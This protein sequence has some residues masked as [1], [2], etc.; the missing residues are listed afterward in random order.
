MGLQFRYNISRG[1]TTYA[2]MPQAL[3]EEKT[4]DDAKMSLRAAEF[5]A[6]AGGNYELLPKGN[7]QM[8]WECGVDLAPPATI[9]PRKPKMWSVKKLTMERSKA[10]KVM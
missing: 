2:F 10:Y 1:P 8:L 5:G 4:T 3:S 6:L 7:V 9:R